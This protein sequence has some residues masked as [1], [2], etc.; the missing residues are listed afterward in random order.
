MKAT[1]KQPECQVSEC[2]ESTGL[3]QVR[4]YRTK[5]GEEHRYFICRAHRAERQRRYY[6]TRGRQAVTRAVQTY[7]L[8]NPER[9]KAWAAARSIPLEPCEWRTGEDR[10][11]GASRGI[12]R[13]HEDPA[14]QLD[15]V[16]LCP[17]HH[18][19]RHRQLKASQ[20][21]LVGVAA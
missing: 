16:F 9:R 21:Q 20:L 12:H 7:V 14:K 2:T 19:R 6:A 5:N 18:K 13:H 3:V 11:C 4:I 8:K 10:Q 17:L 1:N 15:V